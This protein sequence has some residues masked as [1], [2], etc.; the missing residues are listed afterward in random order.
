[1]PVQPETAGEATSQAEDGVIE[2]APESVNTPEK[3]A[4]RR[5]YSPKNAFTDAVREEIGMDP[6]VAQA[7][8]RWGATWDAAIARYNEAL[9]AGT[10]LAD[11]ILDQFNRYLRPLTDDE[12]AVLE[13]E[14]IRQDISRRKSLEDMQNQAL[15]EEKRNAAHGDLIKAQ[16]K[17]ADIITTM[18]QTGTLTARAL[19]FRKAIFT[20][21][22]SLDTMISSYLAASGTRNLTEQEKSAAVKEATEQHAKIQ[23]KEM[24]RMK[25]EQ[26]AANAQLQSMMEQMFADIKGIVSAAPK[27]KALSKKLRDVLKK[28][29][30]ESQ[31]RMREALS[32]SQS[33][34]FYFNPQTYLDAAIILADKIVTVGAK[35]FDY[36]KELSAMIGRG[37]TDEEVS[38]VKAE[39][40]RVLDSLGFT[41]GAEPE[42]KT[43]RK[44]GERKAKADIAKES[45][46]D[47]PTKA[48]VYEAVKSAYIA[49]GKPELSQESVEAI[50]NEIL[51]QFQENWPEI[52]VTRLKEIF[53]DYGKALFPSKEE[54][55]VA[56]REIRSMEQQLLHLERMEKGQKPERTGPQRDKPSAAIR[57]LYKKVAEAKKKHGFVSEKSTDLV[58][59]L[60][61]AKNRLKNQ[62]EDIERA[63]EKGGRPP[64]LRG[65]RAAI[66][67]DAEYDALVKQRDELRETLLEIEGPKEISMERRIE[68]TLRGLER[69]REQ[70]ERRVEAKDYGKQVKPEKDVVTSPEIEEERGYIET[71]RAEIKAGKKEIREDGAAERAEKAAAARYLKQKAEYQRRI[72]EKDVEPKKKPEPKEGP[73]TEET[74]KAYDSMIEARE[75]YQAYRE[76]RRADIDYARDKKA[77]K[78][79]IETYRKKLEDGD[80]SVPKKR[81]KEY[82]ARLDDLRAQEFEAKQEWAVKV[83]ER[84]EAEY[85]NLRKFGLASMNFLGFIRAIQTGLDMGA[86]L[87]QAGLTLTTNPKIVYNAFKKSLKAWGKTNFLRYEQERRQRANYKYYI[88]D[89]LEI[90]SITNVSLTKMEEELQS[91]WINTPPKWMRKV[92]EWADKSKGTGTAKAAAARSLWLSGKVAGGLYWLVQG[93]ARSYETMINEGRVASYDYYA[94]KLAKKK[95]K[96]AQKKGLTTA[97]NEIRSD[98]YDALAQNLTLT[99]V[100]NP[101]EGRYIADYV[102]TKTGRG[103][104]PL[105]F[106]RGATVLSALMFSP[107]YA[108]SRTRAALYPI[109][110]L[111]GG[112]REIYSKK[113]GSIKQGRADAPKVLNHLRGILILEEVKQLAVLATI[114]G[115]TALTRDEDDDDPAELDPRAALF[116]KFVVDGTTIDVTAGIGPMYQLGARIAYGLTHRYPD[117]MWEG[118]KNF[119]SNRGVTTDRDAWG[120]LMTW[121]AGKKSPPLNFATEV[122]SGKD[123]AGNNTTI[124]KAMLQLA[125]PIQYGDLRD[126]FKKHGWSMP[127][128]FIGM[129]SF[130]GAGVQPVLD[131]DIESIERDDKNRLYHRAVLIDP[132]R[133]ESL[134]SIAKANDE[135]WSK[136]PI[137]PEQRKELFKRTSK[138]VSEA[139]KDA[140]KTYDDAKS[141][142]DNAEEEEA[143]RAEVQKA[144]NSTVSDIREIEMWK[145]MTEKK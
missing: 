119:K 9:N 12:V 35:A 106:E 64:E 67:G 68:L 55:K 133:E 79:R 102:N 52:E 27:T 96:D 72:R 70:L 145:M 3:V 41:E 62:I 54:I 115:L 4:E 142:W 116:G 109:T 65:K 144:L 121:L 135:P 124:G 143:G 31:A 108:A 110:L 33:G 129:A 93:S 2:G 87:R 45:G 20:E 86:T 99:G 43:A 53:T 112:A 73:K 11:K 134:G 125:E 63:I 7:R 78:K 66:R 6:R 85:S 98:S 100:P 34:G 23:E 30:E 26:E 92:A 39:A 94:E 13:Y 141:D 50:F 25:A 136:R 18:T 8:K 75:E 137:T 120:L 28:K 46:G 122:L 48:D 37:A 80:F 103:R 71:L 29:A 16:A 57:E 47:E 104:L 118:A 91:R 17:L 84:K 105:N 69:T 90:P 21:E 36:A 32:Q 24:S 83:L 40:E 14:F 56:M 131:E 42:V 111:V 19:A 81:Q 59:A 132:I 89:G 10:N 95:L 58:G 1:M 140:I 114:L 82:D 97:L 117:G 74:Q 123:F 138:E 77:I 22:Y 15:S 130:L 128:I 44:K 101:D 60:E 51:P 113:Y 126:V 88:R 127:S 5:L 38:K 49:S 107:R 139:V 76:T 61:A